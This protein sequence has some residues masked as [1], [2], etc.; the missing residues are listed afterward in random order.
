MISSIEVA[1]KPF[2]STEAS[3]TSRMRSRVSL[4]LRGASCMARGLLSRADCT[5]GPLE[6]PREPDAPPLSNPASHI[7]PENHHFGGTGTQVF[8]NEARKALTFLPTP[9]GPM[10]FERNG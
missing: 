4:P 10:P 5:T 6:N 7:S 9:L 1:A 3:A 8:W 2:S